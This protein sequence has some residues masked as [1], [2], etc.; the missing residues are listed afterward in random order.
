[1]VNGK[2]DKLFRYAAVTVFFTV[3]RV[4]DFRFVYPR[5]RCFPLTCRQYNIYSVNML[6]IVQVKNSG[7]VIFPQL[8]EYSSRNSIETVASSQTFEKSVK[9]SFANSPVFGIIQMPQ[10]IAPNRFD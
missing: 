5:R 4:G 2:M 1:M 3:L 7:F 8:T 10:N 9:Q 6:W